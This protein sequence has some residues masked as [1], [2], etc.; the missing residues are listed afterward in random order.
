VKRAVDNMVR[1]RLLLCEDAD[2][3]IERLVGIGLAAG[4][5]AP[6]GD[7]SEP[8]LRHCAPRNSKGGEK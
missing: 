4:I 7:L 3:Q 1:D 8:E 2:D 5:P 6:D